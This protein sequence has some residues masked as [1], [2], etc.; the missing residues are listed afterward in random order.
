METGA[1]VGNALG[2]LSGDREL[3]IG[4]ETKDI[5]MLSIGVFVA[6]LLALLISKHI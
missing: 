3:R 4:I 5:I 2:V 1:Q 6:M